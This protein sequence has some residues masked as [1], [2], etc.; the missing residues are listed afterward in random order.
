M[1][2]RNQ[3]NP[4]GGGGMIEGHNQCI[5]VCFVRSW[6]FLESFSIYRLV[7]IFYYVKGEE[8]RQTLLNL[9]ALER[10]LKH[11]KSEDI[12]I[13]RHATMCLGTLCQNGKIKVNQ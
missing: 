9:G 1:L 10:L 2:K 13:R 4:E 11:I 12:I 5:G 7:R 3:G 8:N 6:R